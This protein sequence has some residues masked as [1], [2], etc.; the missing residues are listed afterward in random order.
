MTTREHALLIEIRDL[1]ADVMRMQED[2]AWQQ[3]EQIRAIE[4]FKNANDVLADENADLVQQLAD[5]QMVIDGQAY[6]I[7]QLERE[8]KNLAQIARESMTLIGF[9]DRAIR[10]LESE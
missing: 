2:A 1:K 5:A 9:D 7:R 4:A 10:R 3:R 8:S 6:R